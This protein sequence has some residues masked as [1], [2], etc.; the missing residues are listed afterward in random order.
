MYHTTINIKSLWYASSLNGMQ[1][2]LVTSLLHV[3]IDY[4]KSIKFVETCTHALNTAVKDILVENIC[5][6][7]HTIENKLLS[8]LYLQHTNW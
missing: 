6:A 8:L 1:K 2:Q 4:N 5:Y 3:S 7:Y